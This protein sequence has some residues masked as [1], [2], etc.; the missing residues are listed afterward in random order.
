MTLQTFCP[1]CGAALVAGAAFCGSCGSPISRAA[2][3][4]SGG[5]SPDYAGFWQRFIA[6]L[7]DGVI[8]IFVAGIPAL[9]I[10]VVTESVFLGYAISLVLYIGYFG[11]GNGSGGTW[12]KQIIGI[13]VVALESGGNIGLG[14]GLGRAI[15][16]WLG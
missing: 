9:L 3:T 4:G 5:A 14:A 11:W 13:R 10:G 1:A 8:V 7:I 12:G 15:V 6:G 16:W 2:G